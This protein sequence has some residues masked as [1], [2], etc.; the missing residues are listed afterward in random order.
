MNSLQA[1]KAAVLSFRTRFET[2]EL[3]DMR[4]A[5]EAHC[6]PQFLWRGVHPFLEINGYDG[7]IDD[8]W[9]PLS[10]AFNNLQRRED[11]FFAGSNNASGGKGEW[12]CSM[13]HFCGLFDEDFLSIPRSG[14]LANLRYTEFFRVEDGQ[15][16]EGALFVDMIGLMYDAGCYPLPP[17]TG[18]YFR[19]PGP[20]TQD[21][22]LLEPQ[23]DAETKTTLDLVNLMIEDL[24]N[25]NDL[26]EYRCPPDLL[27]R[28]WNEDMIWY[29][30]CGIGASYTVER[31]QE[32]HQYPFR[33]NL[34]EKSYQGHVAR[35]AEGH[36]C[37]FFGWANLKNR[38]TGGFLGLPAAR[39]TAEM[40]IVD[41]YRREGE[42][43]SENWV[44]I[45]LPHYLAQ[46]GLDVF[47]RLR[48]LQ[49]LED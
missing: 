22:L 45:D 8:F 38:N 28:T 21:G 43:L 13:G 37:G 7:V 20:R 35:I 15:L 40:R 14:R 4:Q 17:M 41:I 48:A 46:Q 1:A 26:E 24:R 5:A 42:K 6:D 36:Y 29:G 3:T 19:Y 12:V 9:L 44:F 31:Y 47:G 18:T 25:L 32:Q 33:L 49:R 11:I 39:D 27:R 2:F 10:R 30:P 23:S 34:T 16:C